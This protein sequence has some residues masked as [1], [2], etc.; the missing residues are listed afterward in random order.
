MPGL[1]FVFSEP[2]PAVSEAEFNDWYDNE[3]VP[4]RLPVPAFLSWSRYVATDDK[5]PSYLA[6]YDL[7]HPNAINE[8][9][10]STLAD[11]RSDREKDIISRLAVLDRRSYS[12]HEV[13]HPPRAGD[14]YD[15]RKPGPY[16]SIVQMDIP[17][18]LVDEFNKWYDEEHIPLFSKIPQWERSRRFV[19]QDAGATGTDESLKPEGGRPQRFLAIHEW[20]DPSATETEQFKAALATPWTKRFVGIATR[21]ERRL[22]KFTRSWERQ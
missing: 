19:L 5:K 18:E 11:T 14:A 4:L 8:P 21:F 12:L 2:G 22:F 13:V 10:Y 20:S 1:L 7:T 15:P 17:D 6:L 9:P 16:L 3:H